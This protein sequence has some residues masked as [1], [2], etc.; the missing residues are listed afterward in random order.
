[1]K[2]LI[3]IMVFSFT[4]CFQFLEASELQIIAGGFNSCKFLKR[5]KSEKKELGFI[6]SDNKG[7]YLQYGATPIGS[8]MYKAFHDYAIRKD[9]PYLISCFTGLLGAERLYYISSLEPDVEH[10]IEVDEYPEFVN[11]FIE[12]YTG[13]PI[14]RAKILGHSHGGWLVMQIVA[15]LNKKIPVD[16]LITVDPISFNSCNRDFIIQRQ[17]KRLSKLMTW[18][19]VYGG[20]VHECARELEKQKDIS[21]R[22]AR[23]ECR[24]SLKEKGVSLNLLQYVKKLYKDPSDGCLSAPWEIND[25]LV[26]DRVD[27]WINYYQEKSFYLHS[28]T[29]KYADEN[30]FID[31]GHVGIDTEQEIWIRHATR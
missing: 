24:Y 23:K 5:V 2:Y 19:F 28:S 16:Q 13:D 9:Q 21:G 31:K 27:Y 7:F 18:P 30:I 22:K 8:R 14:D 6:E 29:Y 12:Y 11:Q 26:S 20:M 17:L 4:L 25:H 10:T 1:M 15:Q 3:L